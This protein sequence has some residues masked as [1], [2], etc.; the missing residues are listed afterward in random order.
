MQLNC[1]PLT[2][3]LGLLLIHVNVVASVLCQIVELL[4]VVIHRT[5]PLVQVQEL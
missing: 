1:E 4:G 2:K 3:E 5:V